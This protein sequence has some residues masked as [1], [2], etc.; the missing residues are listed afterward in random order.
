M[1]EKEKEM[2][3]MLIDNDN[4]VPFETRVKKII[5]R[6]FRGCG[7]TNDDSYIDVIRDG[8]RKLSHFKPEDVSDRLKVLFEHIPDH[9]KMHKNDNEYQITY[10]M[11]SLTIRDCESE[12]IKRG[13]MEVRR[14]VL[15]EAIKVF[16]ALNE[17]K[18]EF[19][20]DDSIPDGVL[21]GNRESYINYMKNKGPW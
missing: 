11:F 2:L 17:D 13:V 18:T 19:I 14:K 6:Y 12:S 7:I 1:N 10:P 15:S 20:V 3:E 5:D 8:C 16:M 9:I 4:S 21:I